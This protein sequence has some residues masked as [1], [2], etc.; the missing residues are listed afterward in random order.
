MLLKD[1]SEGHSD[2]IAI[3]QRPTIDTSIDYERITDYGPDNSLSHGAPIEFTIHP[4]GPYYIDLEK[5]RLNVVIQI[6][7][8]DGS[9]LEPGK[10][11]AAL[12]NLGLHSLFQQVDITMNQVNIT[13]DV[14][15]NYPYKAIF[16]T[17][18]NFGEDEKESFLQSE[19][20]F[21]DTAGDM[22]DIDSAGGGNSGLRMRNSLT[23]NSKLCEFEGPLCLDIAQQKRRIP[24]GVEICVKLIPTLDS[25]RLMA[26]RD[27]TYKV[28]IKSARLRVYEVRLN[29]SVLVGHNE[30]FEHGNAFFPH[31]KSILKT[32][33]IPSGSYDFSVENM[34][35]SKVPSRLIVAMVK[36]SAYNGNYSKNPFNF[37]HF[38][39][40]LIDFQV[41]NISRPG[42]P[43]LLDFDNG[44]YVTAYNNLYSI[45]QKYRGHESD[46]ITRNDFGNGYAMY[47][48]Q[49]SSP[50]RKNFMQLPRNGLTSLHLRF[51][52]AL[53]E[54]V[55]IITYADFPG[56]ME[57][58]KTR[59]VILS[60]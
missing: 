29:D 56:F 20:Y 14:G 52:R 54:P 42:R 33:N 46:F 28:I 12:V 21:K 50:Q 49:V 41:D 19:G 7:K 1:F 30:A 26:G 60:E 32:Y 57:I 48:F 22:E 6:T 10:D 53:S 2:S 25:F 39:M 24:N 40:S 4:N 44:N 11:K 43:I 31:S 58:D 35:Q 9:R 47:V 3:F 16:D 8:S 34:F 18:L 38:N 27:A 59:N 37:A 17:V 23:F 36:S 15:R 45:F 55:T 51:K 5:T 13:R